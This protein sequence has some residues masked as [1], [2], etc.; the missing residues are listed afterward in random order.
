ME[1]GGQK[2]RGP[3]SNPKE[4]SLLLVL[5]NYMAPILMGQQILS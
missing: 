4:G 2:R 3:G 1:E 5:K